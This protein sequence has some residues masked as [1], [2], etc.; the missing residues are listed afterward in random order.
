MKRTQVI[1]A[2]IQKHRYKD[3]LEI[4]TYNPKLNFDLIMAPH[5]VSVEPYPIP[6]STVSFVG[7]SDEYFNSINDTVKFDV[8]FIDGLHLQEQ[9]TL[10]IQNSLMHL[11]ENGIIVCH[12]C[13]PTT[14]E[15]QTRYDSGK[16][17]TGDVWKSIAKLRV[18]ATHLEVRVVDTDCG[19]ALIRFGKNVSFRSNGEDYLTYDYYNRHK[20]QLM[21]VTTIYNFWKVYLHADMK[22]FFRLRIHRIVLSAIKNKLLGLIWVKARNSLS[23]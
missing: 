3:Y 20:A 14:E 11:N 12:D 10:D 23:R 2:L 19:C 4:G 8:V 7:T 5:K 17:W 6:G 18:E 13:L 22:L 15:M 9:L 21:N 1:N 16:E